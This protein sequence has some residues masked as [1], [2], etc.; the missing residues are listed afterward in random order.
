MQEMYF[1][2]VC[3]M[4]PEHGHHINDRCI[5][6]LELQEKVKKT[7]KESETKETKWSE[8]KRISR[9]LFAHNQLIDENLLSGLQSGLDS[10]HY[11]H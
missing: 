9:K 5:V 7:S 11:Y 1:Y 3:P 10:P 8:L 4:H 2:A 6:N